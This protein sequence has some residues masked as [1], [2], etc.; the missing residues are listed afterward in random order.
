[1]TVKSETTAKYKD[2][3]TKAKYKERYTNAKYK[4]RYTCAKRSRRCAVATFIIVDTMATG[5]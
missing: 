1:M 5:L 2:R 4:D 3:Y